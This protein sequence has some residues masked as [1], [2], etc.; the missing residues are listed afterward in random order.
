MMK[1]S[2][3]KDFIATSAPTLPEIQILSNQIF[4]TVIPGL[5]P[6]S[7]VV[8]SVSNALQWLLV[9][10]LPAVRAPPSDVQLLDA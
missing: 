3:A 8:L 6:I 5:R 2:A 7:R 10:P 1:A 9:G 4:S